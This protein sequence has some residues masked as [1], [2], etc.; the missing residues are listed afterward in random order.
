TPRSASRVS[1]QTKAAPKVNSEH[2]P[3]AASQAASPPEK[4]DAIAETHGS[5]QPW[6][7]KMREKYGLK[8]EP[9][10]V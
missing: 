8:K 9:G 10:K 6:R 2:A 4:V 7:E 1:T 3:A 5:N